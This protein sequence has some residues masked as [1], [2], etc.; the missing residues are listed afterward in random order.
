M[1]NRVDEL[2]DVQ[3]E[4]AA[5]VCHR[6][7]DSGWASDAAV[8]AHGRWRA[9]WLRWAEAH[10]KA[11]RE[12]AGER[13]LAEP[14]AE[15]LAELSRRIKREVA[16]LDVSRRVVEDIETHALAHDVEA[17]STMLLLLADA[18]AGLE[19]EIGQ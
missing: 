1:T 18:L 14:L 17:L 11:Q 5:I 4:D 12:Q 10:D 9:S 7:N 3:S 6:I 8:Q 2:H 16:A 13:T 19:T 15:P